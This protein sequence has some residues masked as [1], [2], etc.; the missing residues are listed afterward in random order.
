MVLF[1]DALN[2]FYSRLY[3]VGLF[4]NP[5]QKCLF[6]KK[7]SITARKIT[8]FTSVKI[9]LVRDSNPGPLA[10]KARIIPLDQRADIDMFVR[11]P[12][13]SKYYYL[14]LVLPPVKMR[15]RVI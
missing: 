6:L 13:E 10:P 2:T 9:G 15:V 8:L 5:H 4:L 3:G 11:K 1:I 7:I 14:S 12:Y